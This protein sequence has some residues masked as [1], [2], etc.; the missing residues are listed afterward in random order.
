MSEQ[1]YNFCPVCGSALK[2]GICE[3]CGYTAPVFSQNNVTVTGEAS[4]GKTDIYG[5]E[6]F[7]TPVPKDDGKG[8][9]V[10]LAVFSTLCIFIFVMV[11]QVG[12]RIVL[13]S[14]PKVSPA[15]S[16]SENINFTYTGELADYFILYKS[17][18]D[19][20]G[21]I[22]LEDKAYSHS[23]SPYYVFD[24]YIDNSN[25]YKTLL[26]SW[27]YSN[28]D[29]W[30]DDAGGDFPKDLYIYCEYPNFKN[31][32]FDS[33]QLNVELYYISVG[34]AS[35][36]EDM[37]YTCEE[38]EAIYLQS[39][40]YITY[41]DQNVVSILYYHNAYL[42]TDIFTE[43][44]AYKSLKTVLVSINVDM[45]T[46]KFLRAKDLFN[47]DSAFTD[48]LISECFQQNDGADITEYYSNR[49]IESMISNDEILWFYT[50]LGIEYGVNYPKGYGFCTFSCFDRNKFAK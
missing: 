1:Q 32:S 31:T 18:L 27:S 24:D 48:T 39:T 49:D 14:I 12:Y 43:N 23:D 10:F 45:K 13:N 19:N 5:Q 3:Q 4:T 34:I 26:K 7:N 22:E 29:G 9:S 25:G 8:I 50:P 42:V 6:Y 20:G 41:M 28:D 36:Y 46:G 2:D 30:F 33:T 38:G 40:P 21:S 44:E 37:N 15:A 47:L 17:S 16:V 35:L 11:L